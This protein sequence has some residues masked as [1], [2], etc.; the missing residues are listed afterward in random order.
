[1]KIH[2]GF[3]IVLI[4]FG[5]AGWIFCFLKF[6][7]AHL[8]LATIPLVLGIQ[9]FQKNKKTQN[10][11]ITLFVIVWLLLF[12]YE[13]VKTFYLEP[14]FKRPLAKTK[15][16]FPPAGWI[17]YFNVDDTFGYYEVFGVKGTNI[18]PLD[19]HEVIRTRTIM[20]DNIHRGILGTAANQAHAP[21]FCRYLKFR[22]PEFDKFVVTG[23][24]YPSISKE[25]YNRIQKILYQ[26]TE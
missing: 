8:F 13:S 23:N 1:M 24:Y 4:A 15:F 3:T 12:T 26:C 21:K 11:L 9:F 20:F 18:V 25:P 22:F 2:S 16:L 10:I 5:L 19:P 7:A 14:F 17:M 6:P